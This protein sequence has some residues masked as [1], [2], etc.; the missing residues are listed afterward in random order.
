MIDG[1]GHRIACW[2]ANTVLSGSIKMIHK[3]IH[4]SYAYIQHELNGGNNID[5]HSQLVNLFFI[6]AHQSLF[7]GQKDN[8]RLQPAS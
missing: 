7:I 5:H 2:P 6:I 1:L 3:H 4:I 8:R